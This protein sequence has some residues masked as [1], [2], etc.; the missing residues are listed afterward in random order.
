[1]TKTATK[2]A[3]K[4]D[5]AAGAWTAAKEAYD[6]A[7][8]ALKAA[9]AALEALVPP[10]TEFPAHLAA[11]GLKW[12]AAERLVVVDQ[13]AFLAGPTVCQ[14]TVLDTAKARAWTAV[15]GQA[16]PG[17]GTQVTWSLRWQ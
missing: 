16:V 17:T 1:M 3:H 7:E 4:V 6:A 10:G 11:A 13:E 14:K 2:T 15:T 8:A 12:Q 9:R 5:A